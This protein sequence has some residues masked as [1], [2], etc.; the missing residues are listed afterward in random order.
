MT[1]SPKL[2]KYDL[3]EMLHLFSLLFF[4]DEHYGLMLSQHKKRTYK[5]ELCPIPAKPED[6]IIK[7]PNCRS[8]LF[9][10]LRSYSLRI[11]DE[12]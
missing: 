2:L 10:I 3:F 5:F 11:V 7:S 9:E 6:I 1:K 8:N 12:H 4:A